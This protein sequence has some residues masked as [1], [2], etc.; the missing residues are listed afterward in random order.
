MG[1]I[2]MVMLQGV[3][4]VTSVID[5]VRSCRTLFL[6]SVIVVAFFCGQVVDR[7]VDG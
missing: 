5:S 6:K 4:R 1:M 2:V 7:F 3:V